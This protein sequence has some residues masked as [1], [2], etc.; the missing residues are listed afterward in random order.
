MESDRRFVYL[1]VAL[2]PVGSVGLVAIWRRDYPRRG[3]VA[4]RE[5]RL[6]FMSSIWWGVRKWPA[7]FGGPI[8]PLVGV[9][10]AVFPIAVLCLLLKSNFGLLLMGII[11]PVVL[12]CGLFV[13]ILLVGLLFGWP[14]MWPTV[15]A[16][17]TDSFDAL[18]RSYS[19]TYQR[20]VHYLFYAA[21]AGVLGMLAWVVVLIFAKG[22]I[23]Y[24]YWAA[25]WGSGGARMTEIID[26]D[27]QPRRRRDVGLRGARHW[28]LGARRENPG[29]GLPVQLFLVRGH[30]HLLLA[31]AIG[32][33]HG[34]GRSV[35]RRGAGIV[36]PA[37]VKDRA[38]P[39]AASRGVAGGGN[40]ETGVIWPSLQVQVHSC[41]PSSDKLCDRI[42]SIC[43]SNWPRV[44]TKSQPAARAASSFAS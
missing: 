4:V 25:S 35:R 43:E 24:S 29:R 13:A 15:S 7:Y 33:C 14:L 27:H 21:V 23:V 12:L 10:L 39:A 9:F 6:S 41:W 22:V 20:P 44:R 2:W 16:E 38:R 8:F 31:A 18:S 40:G 30:I 11:W 19:Y 1:S 42:A 3:A 17:G 37:P 5:E 34:N 36:R 26:S 32:R 28:L